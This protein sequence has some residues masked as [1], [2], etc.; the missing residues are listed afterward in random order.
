MDS[1][2]QNFGSG[3][4]SSPFLN[5][6]HLPL[7]PA[8]ALDAA[9]S[10]GVYS[11]RVYSDRIHLNPVHLE[12][13]HGVIGSGIVVPDP[14]HEMA[15]HEISLDASEGLSPLPSESTLDPASPA[16]S[17]HTVVVQPVILQSTAQFAPDRLDLWADA[18]RTPLFCEIPSPLRALE[19][20]PG[21][22]PDSAH[23]PQTEADSTAAS[24]PADPDPE[25]LSGSPNRV[26][27]QVVT[28]VADYF[29]VLGEPTRLRLLN[30]LRDGDRCVQELVEALDTSQANVSKH[31]KVMVQAGIL[32]R[33]SE[34]NQAYYSVDDP[35]TFDLCSLV[36]E[37]IATRIERQ[38]ES[39]RA[40]SFT[41]RDSH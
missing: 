20:T 5:F 17:P 7:H 19:S 23:S 12:A 13:T 33:R 24:S 28:Q 27:Q 11:D 30:L 38:A 3:L 4:G 2:P 34:G 40:F 10:D 21:A 6:C 9:E 25:N 41:H 22:L 39:F 26:P 14:S 36:C 15:Q 37:R 32:T 35:L 8:I 16:N 18:T 29:S 31:L 1:L